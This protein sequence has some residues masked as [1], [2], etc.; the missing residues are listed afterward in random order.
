MF[1]A[2]CCYVIICAKRNLTLVIFVSSYNVVI[3]NTLE[4]IIEWNL[5]CVR[6]PL[7]DNVVVGNKLVFLLKVNIK[8]VRYF[9]P[10]I[11]FM[12]LCLS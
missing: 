3:R 12:C 10:Y 7:L 6:F 11:V 8:H 9:S 2:I 4:F 1:E 5:A